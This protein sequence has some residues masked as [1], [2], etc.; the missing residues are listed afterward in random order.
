MLQQICAKISETIVS[1]L[2]SQTEVEDDTICNPINYFNAIYRLQSGVLRAI[3]LENTGF[4]D[5]FPTVLNPTTLEKEALGDF[6]KWFVQQNFGKVNLSDLYELMLLLEFPVR[7]GEITADAEHLDS[8]GSFYTPSDLADKIVEITLDNYIF[9]QLGITRFSSSNKVN[10]EVA[11]VREFLLHSTFADYSCGTGSFLLAILRYCTNY[12]NAS[13]D[14]LQK[15]ALNFHAI[16]ADAL[17]LEIA[18]LQILEAVGDFSLYAELSPKF[19]HGNPLIAPNEE[20]PEFDFCHE[21]YYNNG[22]AL[23]PEQIPSCDVVVGN[24]PWGT[25]DF[26]L[27]NYFHLLCPKLSELENE[28]ELEEAFEELSN[29]HPE[30]YCWF[31]NHD[32]AVDLAMEDIYNDER[33]A[34]STMGGLH[35]NVLFT[36]LCNSL[37]TARGSV[38]LVLKGSTLSN[39]I[40][41]RLLNHL[42]RS[43]RF[44]SRYDLINCNGIFN[45]N[46]TEEFSIVVLGN[47]SSEYLH[48][49]GLTHLSEVD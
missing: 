16:E 30:L 12:L 20:Y 32:E 1:V 13:Q 28:N 10:D 4:E 14:L 36:E 5:A 21:L 35:T 6:V 9:Q 7:D 49:T 23:Q 3:A 24:P 47:S 11:Q 33:F 45:I 39:P 2:K 17:S 34:H 43:N 48:R 22:L 19:I 8:I 26:E 38:G 41:K 40:N 42:N 25:V 31:L 29:T 44:V 15:I 18:K 27:P 46:R 37:C